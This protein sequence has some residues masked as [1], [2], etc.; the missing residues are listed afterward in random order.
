[1]LALPTE[2][3][4]VVFSAEHE[5]AAMQGEAIDFSAYPWAL[6]RTGRRRA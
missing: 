6:P 5:I 3:L 1:M 2:P 4:A